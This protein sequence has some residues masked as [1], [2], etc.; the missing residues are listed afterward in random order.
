MNRWLERPYL[1]VF[2]AIGAAAAI[3]L[4]ISIRRPS[5][6]A[7]FRLV[8]VLFAAAFGTLAVSFWPYMIPFSITIDEA[9]APNASLA[10]MCWGAGLFV[11]PL[12][13]LNTATITACSEAGSGR[14]QIPIINSSAGDIA[15]GQTSGRRHHRD[16]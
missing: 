11:F 15:N 12:M 5:D 7:P 8:A 9:A 16:A 2:P 1:L 13:L 4:G 14:M 3:L 6:Q 10:F